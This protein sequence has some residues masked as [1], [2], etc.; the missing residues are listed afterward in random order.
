MKS[1]AQIKLLF[2]TAVLTI[3]LWSPMY[4]V[5]ALEN[6]ATSSTGINRNNR[7]DIRQ[8]Q[9]EQ[10]KIEMAQRFDQ[11]R[12]RIASREAELRDRLAKFQDQRKA[13]I[14]QKVSENLNRINKNRTDEMKKHL[15]TLSGIL[16]KVETRASSSATTSTTLA[17]AVAS[18]SDAISNAQS[19]VANQAS[20]DYTINATSEATL[21]ADVKVKRDQL[22]SDLTAVRQQVISSREA[23]A[24]A[25]KTLLASKGGSK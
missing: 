17:T 16:G 21:R 7:L 6:T 1:S 22:F 20:K 5:L 4:P 25:I 2:P 15:E 18:A 10:R 12:V 13:Q 23:V 19:A 8:A 14:T 24:N 11:A 3:M 9:L